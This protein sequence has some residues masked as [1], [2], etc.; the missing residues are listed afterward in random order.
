[1]DGVDTAKKSME[2]NKNVDLFKVEDV[3]MMC[4]QRDAMLVP[5]V[6]KQLA[7][8]DK[9]G[10]YHAEIEDTGNCVQEWGDTFVRLT[11]QVTEQQGCVEG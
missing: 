10:C 5:R 8:G 6:M 7:R 11:V 9:N 1:M 3:F 2:L 4:T